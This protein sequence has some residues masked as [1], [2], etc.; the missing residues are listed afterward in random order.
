MY[1]RHLAT[2]TVLQNC[3]MPS[4]SALLVCGF[5][6][7]RKYSLSSCHMFSIG[8]QSGLS[9]GVF[10]QFIPSSSMNPRTSLDVCLGSLS[11]ISLCV[12]SFSL[13]K[14]SRPARRT[15]LYPS[16]SIS[17]SK[18]TIC[19]APT[20]LTP[21]HTWTFVGCFALQGK[22]IISCNSIMYM[23]INIPW[24]WSRLASRLPETMAPVA[25]K[26]NRRFI[27]PDDI[28]KPVSQSSR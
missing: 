27:R 28:G 26:L 12:G 24:L 1:L 8:L 10:H 4:T 16:A 11:C 20:Q 15:L 7:R 14:G 25:L 23:C 2:S 5:I 22:V 18:M 21:A 17:P 19:V 9:A 13:M 6:S 3:W